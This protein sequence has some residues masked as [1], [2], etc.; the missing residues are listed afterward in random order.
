VGAQRLSAK[1]LR[2]VQAKIGVDHLEAAWARGG[3]HR[4]EARVV[5]PDGSH[6]H[7]VIDRIGGWGGTW[8]WG[9]VADPIHRASCPKPEHE[10]EVAGGRL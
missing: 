10:V 3:T 1:T 4:L 5:Y 2:R 7:L 6:R 9:W 8:S